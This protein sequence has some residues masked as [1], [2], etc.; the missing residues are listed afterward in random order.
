MEKLSLHIALNQKLFHYSGKADFF[1]ETP[2]MIL[3]TI[4]FT[5]ER[6]PAPLSGGLKI[7]E[8]RRVVPYLSAVKG[9]ATLDRQRASDV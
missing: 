9:L 3:I 5:A 1:S 6:F 7:Q 8:I 4:P 2:L